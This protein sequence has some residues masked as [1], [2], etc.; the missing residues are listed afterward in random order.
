MKQLSIILLTVAAVVSGG[1]FLAHR[2]NLAPSS[3]VVEF[4]N[5]KV[6][7]E[8]AGTPEARTRGLSGRE[9]LG[10]KS[11]LLF[12]FQESGFY[13]FHMKDMK[14]PIDIIWLD[15][16]LRVVDITPH[17]DPRTY[18]ETFSSHRPAQY[19]LEVNA[20]FAG[21][22]GISRGDIAV[23]DQTHLDSWL[24]RIDE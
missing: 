1:V 9:Q 10:E 15:D 3:T 2:L 6:A 22:H 16:E 21:R 7:A 8:I 12:I 24:S 19:V 14:F 11:G 5:V 18:P 4:K 20:G 13:Y 17:L 23:I